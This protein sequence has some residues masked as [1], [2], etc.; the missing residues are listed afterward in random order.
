MTKINN[1]FLKSGKDYLLKLSCCFDENIF[2]E[3]E[4]LSKAIAKAWEDGNRIFIC[5]NG[6]SSANAQHIAN[7]FLYGI[8]V[9]TC[10][11]FENSRGVSIEALTSNSNI[12][13][14][15]AN[16]IGYENV[17]SYQLKVKAKKND[18][19]VVLSGSGNSQNIIN[20]L[21]FSNSQKINTCAIL[22]FDGGA[23]KKYSNITI[24]IPVNDMEVAEDTQMIIFNIIKKWLIKNKPKN[25]K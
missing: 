23:C 10:G 24:H 4:I 18:L 8:G 12:I 5:G 6:G 11:D 17:F 14:C 2:S 1:D 7:D 25:L 15:L 21:K 22:G 9:P 13:T 20:A 3:I 19:L 16:D